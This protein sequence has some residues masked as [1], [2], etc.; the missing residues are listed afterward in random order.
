MRH[1]NPE[2]DLNICLRDL[3][4]QPVSDAQLD[5]VE[6]YLTGDFVSNAPLSA[7]EDSALMGDSGWWPLISLL[8]DQNRLT[9]D[10]FK[11]SL[12]RAYRAAYL[13]GERRRGGN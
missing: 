13:L 6:R 11:R 9:Y 7:A 2:T 8:F 4:K 12:W 3:L 5:L 1:Y 10:L